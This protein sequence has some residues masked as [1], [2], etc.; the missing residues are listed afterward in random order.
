[1]TL[2]IVF[3][4]LS[5]MMNV[6]KAIEDTKFDFYFPLCRFWQMS[7]GGILAYKYQSRLE[8]ACLGTGSTSILQQL[9]LHQK[10]IINIIS[11]GA[12]LT[13]FLTSYLLP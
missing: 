11:A 9:G 10:I 7:I 5:M 6:E 2:L 13:I 12:L 4:M 8:G 3:T 1:M